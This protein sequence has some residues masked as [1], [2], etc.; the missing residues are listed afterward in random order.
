MN[1][2]ES[3]IMSIKSEAILLKK[4]QIELELAKEKTK[5]LEIEAK[6]K[7]GKKKTGI[8]RLKD[9]D[10]RYVTMKTIVRELEDNNTPI[11]VSALTA[12]LYHYAPSIETKANCIHKAA[13]MGVLDTILGFAKKDGQYWVDKS[14]GIRFKADWLY[15][16]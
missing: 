3:S 5:Q 14:S 6:I 10:S 7:L 13:F 12:I 11:A 15:H 16:E 1:K 9:I 2:V 4:L 8:R